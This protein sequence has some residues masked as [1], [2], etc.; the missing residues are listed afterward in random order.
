MMGA[1]TS[2]KFAS[3]EATQ[4]RPAPSRKPAVPHGLT[5]VEVADPGC[6]RAPR[7]LER[8]APRQDEGHWLRERRR[9]HLAH[10]GVERRDRLERVDHQEPPPAHLGQARERPGGRGQAERRRERA[11]ELLRRRFDRAGVEPGDGDAGLPGPSGQLPA[12]GRLADAAGAGDD[13][14]PRP[15]APESPQEDAKLLKPTKEAGSSVDR[16]RDGLES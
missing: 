10:P 15:A 16:P 8:L 3:T 7:R 11:L 2:V 12:Q 1:I 5:P 14:D 9:E 4:P 6:E 13:D